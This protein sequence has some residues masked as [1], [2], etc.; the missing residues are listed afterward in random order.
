VSTVAQTVL[1]KSP[2]Q[3]DGAGLN[4][5]PDISH[6][7]S[8]PD[9]MSHRLSMSGRQGESDK[10]QHKTNMWDG[11]TI[12]VTG[13]K[14]DTTGDAILLLLESKLPD[15]DVAVLRIQRHPSR[16]VIYITFETTNG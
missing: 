16:D 10:G 5:F 12:E 14:P 3:L 15:D 6:N 2:L 7:Q 1:D 4:V 11:R 13:L 8:R 9:D